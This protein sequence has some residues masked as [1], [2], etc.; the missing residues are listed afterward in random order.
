M[1]ASDGIWIIAVSILLFSLYYLLSFH[2]GTIRLFYPL[3]LKDESRQRGVLIQKLNGFM[4]LGLVPAVLLLLVY[5]RPISDFGVSPAGNNIWWYLAGSIAILV[6]ANYFIGRTRSNL[7][8][9]PLIRHRVWT[10]SRVALSLFFWA[11]YL[12]GYEFFFRGFLF[13]GTIEAFGFW[14]AVIINLLFYSAVHRLHNVQEALAAIP[15]GFLI[16]IIT[17][18]SASVLPAILIHIVLA[19]SNELWSVY[20]HPEM[21]FSAKSI[22]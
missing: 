21:R 17:Y 1:A 11:L 10:P 9:F 5:K 22:V 14:P 2:P 19:W 15:F 4:I 3:A 12:A 7:A 18:Y 8:R 16:C 13:F 20:H 6:P